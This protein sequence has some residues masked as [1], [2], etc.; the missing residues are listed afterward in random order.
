MAEEAPSGQAKRGRGRRTRKEETG[1]HPIDSM[2]Q[3]AKDLSE[4]VGS[5]AGN[6]WR[7]TVASVSGSKEVCALL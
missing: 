3:N 4:T 1:E 5:S 7:S 6:L 2:Y